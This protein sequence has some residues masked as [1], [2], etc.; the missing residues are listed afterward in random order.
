M[1]GEVGHPGPIP[2][3]PNMTVLQALSSAGMTQFANTKKIY[4][5]RV[6]N[7]KQEKLLVNYRKLVKGEQMEQNYMLQPGDTIVVP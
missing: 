3:L 4:V 5:M 2:M 7:G 6:Q 1:V